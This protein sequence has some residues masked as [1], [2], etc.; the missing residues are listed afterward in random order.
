M[1]LTLVVMAVCAGLLGCGA[2][3]SREV[4]AGDAV[5]PRGADA[6]AK[7]PPSIVRIDATPSQVPCAPCSVNGDCGE[8]GAGCVASEGGGPGYCAPGCNKDRYC[9]P[10]RTCA[11]VSDPS[12]LTWA[13]CLPIGGCAATP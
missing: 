5:A 13:A 4:D 11:D 3:T 8:Y 7:E 1:R 2:A 10:D 12:A 6:A 9:A